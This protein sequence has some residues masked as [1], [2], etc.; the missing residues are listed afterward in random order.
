MAKKS[1]PYL[2]KLLGTFFVLILIA[3]FLN[4][5]FFKYIPSAQIDFHHSSFLELKQFETALEKKNDANAKAIESF[6][7]DINKDISALKCNVQIKRPNSPKNKILNSENDSLEFLLLQEKFNFLNYSGSNKKKA[8]FLSFN[9]N[10]SFYLSN[11]HLVS[12]SLYNKWDIEYQVYRKGKNPP[13]TAAKKVAEFRK[14][15]DTLM[16]S[17]VSS[18]K[19][20]FDDYLIIRDNHLRP[21][22]THLHDGEIVFNSGNLSV[23]YL[24]STDSL[25]KKNDGFSLLNV[26]NV[27]I[28]GSSY[29][30]FLYPIKLGGE[31]LILAGLIGVERYNNEYK[32]IPFNLIVL[33]SV[34]VVLTL[35]SMPVLKIYIIGKAEQ[36]TEWD[37]RFLI[38]TYFIG[39][40]VIFFLFSNS[41]L[42]Q[43]IPI[44]NQKELRML[45]NKVNNNF[46]SEID[47]IYTQLKNFDNSFYSSIIGEDCGC[48][49]KSMTNK[50]NFKDSCSSKMDSI[51]MCAPLAYP[52]YK[53]LSWFDSSG[54][55]IAR[56]GAT[57]S[58]KRSPF[59]NVSD[60]KY[61]SDFV[62]GQYLTLPGNPGYNFTIQP[63]LSKLDGEYAVTVAIKSSIDDSV[64]RDKVSGVFKKY[65]INLP[66]LIGMGSDMHFVSNAIPSPG[67]EFSI[68]NEDGDVLYDSKNER[69]LLSNIFKVAS[70]PTSLYQCAR[71]RSERY[72]NSVMLRGREVSLL[73][74]PINGTPYTLLTYYSVY[75]T[76]DM[77]E[78]LIGLSATV[79][80]II[81]SLLLLS[82]WINEWSKKR[83][84]LLQSPRLYFQ[85]LRP[86]KAK[87]FYYCHLI[88]W[89]LIL[90]GIFIA[91]WLFVE[92][93][94]GFPSEFS[95]FFVTVLF[96][97]YVAA[98]YYS[99]REINN[100][101]DDNLKSLLHDLRHSFVFWFL[102]II[103]ITVNCYALA[104]SGSL[105]IMLPQI[106][107]IATICFSVRGLIRIKK[108]NAYKARLRCIKGNLAEIQ[109]ADTANKKNEPEKDKDLN[110]LRTYSWAIVA[111][112]FLISIVPALGVFCLVM[113]Q[114][115]NI[116][117]SSS[118]IEMAHRIY[119]RRLQYNQRIMKDTTSLLYDKDKFASALHKLKFQYGIYTIDSNQIDTVNASKLIYPPIQIVSPA[120][121]N[122]HER[123]F[124]EGSNSSSEDSVWSA[125][126]SGKSW[127][128]FIDTGTNKKQPDSLSIYQNEEDGRNRDLLGQYES[129]SASWSATKLLTNGMLSTGALYY[130]LCFGGGVIWMLAVFFITISLARRVFLIDMLSYKENQNEENVFCNS[131]FLLT[132]D[133]KERLLNLLIY[134]YDDRFEK[135][136]LREQDKY[137]Q[138]LICYKKEE[139]DFLKK[140]YDKI[141]NRCFEKP[142]ND[143]V[144]NK[145]K[146]DENNDETE[147][148]KRYDELTNQYFQKPP[149]SKSEFFINDI[150]KLEDKSVL[151]NKEDVILKFGEVMK[152]IYKEIWDKC[153]KHEKFIL[154]DFAMDGFTNYKNGDVIFGLIRKG[155]L[156]FDENNLL[157]VMTLSFREFI[158]HNKKDKDIEELKTAAKE[159]DTWKNFKIPLLIVLAFIGIFIF[160]TQ[161][162]IYQKITGLLTSITSIVPLLNSFFGSGSN[163]AGK[164]KE[165]KIAD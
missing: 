144:N 67:F 128:Y 106:L 55:V 25:L 2:R 76:E 28:E 137:T 44:N 79:T 11:I 109:N 51:F 89:M 138:K 114:E 90:F 58:F 30:L 83:S 48:I 100:Q 150:Y 9:C 108:E 1:Y 78:H 136:G 34:L 10:D 57:K 32:K 8:T 63:A 77:H 101:I 24:V 164:N 98:H 86:E 96:P 69:A 141:H 6:I 99:I 13:D 97:F 43:L 149:K 118:Q 148:R 85:W 142:Q 107:F 140:M 52:Y 46:V 131:R 82:A 18:Y 165:D 21:D 161:D 15:F 19:D 123:V 133:R 42:N 75:P 157:R 61:F 152:D 56:W 103:I 88:Q 151:D 81:L 163:G 156:V 70:N 68:I 160:F 92:N 125:D 16:L 84:A 71:Y 12:D 121:I 45:S 73:S 155:I 159:Q 87:N 36:I 146:Q 64:I 124:P 154:Y 39:A 95:L 35:I 38:G 129:T 20:I 115:T 134:V 143:I 65:K 50:K 60:R 130:V 122:L 158:L 153:N 23:D 49:I 147:N 119:D 53:S 72:F 91:W 14:D 135:N 104:Y 31:R 145:G 3:I 37:I 116:E 41:F 22:T 40:F 4:L 162:L 26:H 33:I 27:T 93:F 102:L 66:F 105:L 7:N 54:N 5:Y 120:Y 113:K 17:L 47:S 94:R 139:K 62:N 80:G 117:S 127:Y 29:K 132:V 112:I 59:V 126:S 74:R 110:F 111:G